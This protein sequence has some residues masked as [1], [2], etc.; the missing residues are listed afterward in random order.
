VIAHIAETDG[1]ALLAPLR[2]AARDAA[3]ALIAGNIDGYGDAMIV[4]TEAQAALHPALVNPRAQT[5]IDMAREHGAAGWKVNGAGGDGGTVTIIGPDDPGE[6][7]KKLSFTTGLSLVPL[8]PT[9]DG[10][11]IIAKT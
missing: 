5:V 6:L 7:I 2:T 11:R 9:R 10:V 4:N 1:D 3:D 8:R